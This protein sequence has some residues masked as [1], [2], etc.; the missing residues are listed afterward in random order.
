MQGIQ[1]AWSDWSTLNNVI[2]F[3]FV[4]PGKYKVLVESKDLFGK[5]TKLET[6]DFNVV[7]PYWK[8]PWFYALEFLFFGSLVVLSLRVNVTSS[9]YRY[10]SRFLSALTMVLLI[11]FI[12]TI[13]TANMT[14]RKEDGKG[15]AGTAQAGGPKGAGF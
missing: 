4:P 11:Q 2:N 9:R 8:R 1:T 14:D 15:L 6:I 10:L 7:P 5:V 3:S 12:Q 13:A